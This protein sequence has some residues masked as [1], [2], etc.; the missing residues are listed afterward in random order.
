M[1]RHNAPWTADRLAWDSAYQNWPETWR[2]PKGRHLIT[3]SLQLV[4][5]WVKRR[6]RA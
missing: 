1:T 3:H 2:K 6:A 5:E 4:A